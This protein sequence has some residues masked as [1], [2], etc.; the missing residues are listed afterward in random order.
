[1]KENLGNRDWTRLMYK[2]RTVVWR[3]FPVG[4]FYPVLR[5]NWSQSIRIETKEDLATKFRKNKLYD[6]SLGPAF[7]INR[8][9]TIPNSARSSLKKLIETDLRQSMPANGVGLKWC[10]TT[11]R[12][13]SQKT[14]VAVHIL[15]DETIEEIQQ[16]AATKGA[17]I[18]TI[19]PIASKGSYWFDNKRRTDTPIRVW[20]L[21]GFAF[22]LASGVAIRV[23]ETRILSQIEAVRNTVQ[24]A[25]QKQTEKAIALREST[26]QSS[27]QNAA[28]ARDGQLFKR[29]NNRLSSL[30][31]LT[32]I[33]GNETWISEFKTSENIVQISGFTTLDV[34]TVIDTLR[35]SPHFDEVDLNGSITFDSLSR[36]N[37]FELRLRVNLSEANL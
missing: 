34:T 13:I 33:L 35:K 32:D 10:F 27:I 3:F 1:M 8:K 22:I 31:A 26:E 25:T 37:R 18:R 2:L 11:G 28:R 17:S 9:M 7:S 19:G 36:K 5:L 29:D 6:V 20:A 16:A 12:G 23:N 14:D 21:V 4:L 15:K 24:T 30:I